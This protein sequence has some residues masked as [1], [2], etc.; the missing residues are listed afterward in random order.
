MNRLS[1]LILLVA[2]VGLLTGA[3]LSANHGGHGDHAC[4]HQV[5]APVEWVTI[6]EQTECQHCPLDE[7]ASMARCA[8]NATAMIATA[9]IPFVEEYASAWED[10][11]HS[12]E[13]TTAVPPV[14]PPPR[15]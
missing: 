13:V 10:E 9:H 15:A 8:G 7:C 14:L 6:G 4:C 5:N 3:S 2:Q 11:Q 12:R 1:A